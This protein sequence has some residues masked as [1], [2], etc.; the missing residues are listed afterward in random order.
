D[1]LV[2]EGAAALGC[3]PSFFALPALAVGASLIGNTRVIL[4]KRNWTEP[5]VVWA[6]VVSE[7]GT[8]KS[9]AQR[10]V[11]TPAYKIQAELAAAYKEEKAKY[12][13]EK[14]KNEE[15]VKKAKKEGK[16]PDAV[17]PDPPTPGRIVTTD[18][19]IE[20][21]GRLLTDNPN[22]VL[23]ARDELRGW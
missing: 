6:A 9:P 14:E 15:T 4:L 20:G 23:A 7:S 1:M 22:G 11:L 17:L 12:E 8:M 5:S 16:P 3:D 18:V 2:R 21:L 19:T 13:A 10:F